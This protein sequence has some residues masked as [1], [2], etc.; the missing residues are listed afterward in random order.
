MRQSGFAGWS[1]MRLLVHTCWWRAARAARGRTSETPV[2]PP[3]APHAIPLRNRLPRFQFQHLHVRHQFPQLARRSR[4]LRKRPEVHGDDSF[5][6]QQFTGIGGFTRRHGE[7][8]ANG[9]HGDLR[10][11]EIADDGH[12]AEDV[13][14]ARVVELDSVRELEHIPARFAA[15]DDLVAILYSAGMHRVNHGDLH[16]RDGL[17]AAL[18]H[19]CNLFDAFFLQPQAELVDAN[20]DRIELFVYVDRIPDV[21]AMAV[22][23]DQHVG[24]L[25]VLFTLRALGVTG[26]PRIDVEGLPFRRLD[27]EGSVT[28]PCELNSLKIHETLLG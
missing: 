26:N 17:R 24:F 13:G 2:A 19:G 9:Q 10:R 21:L 7:K 27:A 16:T 18:V 14:I 5:R 6:L 4:Q 1:A 12:I 23:A 28:K 22:G 3:E 8:V 25:D 20:G 15:I 11:I